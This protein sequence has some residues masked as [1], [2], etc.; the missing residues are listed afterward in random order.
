MLRVPE[1]SGEMFPDCKTPP[2][3]TSP[4]TYSAPAIPTPP[5]VT[6]EPELILVLGMLF[7]SVMLPV[8]GNPSLADTLIF[9]FTS[10]SASG[11]ILLIPT[12]PSLSIRTT[13]G[14][15]VDVFNRKSIFDPTMFC[16]TIA[17]SFSIESFNWLPVPIVIP[18]L[19]F[20]D[21]SKLD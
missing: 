9:P 14:K 21:R 12:K 6:I 1:L 10:S 11:P 19:F 2:I 18:S 13:V 16:D 17:A 15:A 7:S 8:S 20:I 3:S 4:P 5:A